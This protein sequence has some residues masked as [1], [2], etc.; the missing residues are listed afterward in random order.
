MNLGTA[1]E[2]VWEALLAANPKVLTLRL[3]IP[4][5][6]RVSA[7]PT[8]LALVLRNLLDNALRHSAPGEIV[9]HL[10]G[11]RLAVIDNG[12]GFSAAE[13]AQVFE[14]FFAGTQGV[15]G[16]G[17]ALVRHVCAACGWTA[18][19]GNNAAAGHGEVSIDFATSLRDD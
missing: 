13:L 7:D 3:E 17:L 2:G 19:A 1:I 15:H 4:A 12:P 6:C 16:L 8:L 5:D 14:R 9:C 18:S 10:A 11:T